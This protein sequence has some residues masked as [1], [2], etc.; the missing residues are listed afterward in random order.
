MHRDFN[1]VAMLAAIEKEQINAIAAVPV[2][3]QSALAVPNIR[4]YNFSSLEFI[5][6]GASPMS[7]ALLRQCLDVFDCKFAHGYGQ[8]EVTTALTFLPLEGHSRALVDKPE[9]L[10][11]CGMDGFLQFMGMGQNSKQLCA[12]WAKTR[13]MQIIG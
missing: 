5:S 8:T 6:Y 4:D 7:P 1:P 10:N 12:G 13:N 3:L 2:M 11:S 9:L